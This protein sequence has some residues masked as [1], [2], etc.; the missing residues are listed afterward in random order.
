MAVKENRHP[1]RPADY[2]KSAAY[3]PN[4]LSYD[5][6]NNK[7]HIKDSD[8]N[9]TIINKTENTKIQDSAG[10]VLGTVNPENSGSVT[11][12]DA[13]STKKGLT[14]YSATAPKANSSANAGSANTAARSDH[15]HPLQTNVSG[16]AGTADKLKTKRNISIKGAATAAAVAFDGSENVDLN[17]TSIDVS[18]A[19]G[20]LPISSVPKSA[21]ERVV[22]VTDDD[23]KLKLTIDDI[24]NGDCV[25]VNSTNKMYFVVDENKLGTNEAFTE[26]IVG[27]SAECS[28]SETSDVATKAIQDGEGN[29]IV[30]QYAKKTDLASHIG[31]KNNPHGITAKQIGAL[32]SKP[33]EIHITSGGADFHTELN[34]KVKVL[35]DSL[36]D[37]ES[38]YLSIK[39]DDVSEFPYGHI[40]FTDPFSIDG[41]FNKFSAGVGSSFYGVASAFDVILSTMLADSA[42][43]MWNLRF[44]DVRAIDEIPDLR[45]HMED[46]N[47][48][49]GV[50]AEQVGALPVIK[51]S[52]AATHEDFMRVFDNELSKMK[53]GESK[54]VSLS[55]LTGF[56]T[57][58]KADTCF[59]ILYKGPLSYFY[60][61]INGV[62]ATPSTYR[63]TT[64][65]ELDNINR[66]LLYNNNPHKVTAE[67]VGALAEAEFVDTV[68]DPTSSK[69]NKK[70]DEILSKMPLNSMKML[71]IRDHPAIYDGGYYGAILFKKADTYAA[72]DAFSYSGRRF[73]KIKYDGSWKDWKQED[74]Q[75][76]IVA[77]GISGSWGY[78]KWSNGWAECWNT[79]EINIA[80][81]PTVPIM[82]GNFTTA[83]IRLPFNIVGSNFSGIINIRTGDGIGFGQ[84]RLMSSD[85]A[86]IYCV[87][88]QN[89][90]LITYQTHIICKWK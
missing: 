90:S 34:S 4:E 32:S 82:G 74:S 89:V 19:T 66:H 7:L 41:F 53:D 71:V 64:A 3:Y 36:K 46:K 86:K 39:I 5:K 44:Y 55:S 77:E 75:S 27:T 88:N 8:G 49:H 62:W 23:A 14:Q 43:K 18:K 6:T 33:V 25:K 11:I 54:T 63:I 79:S 2:D 1:I 47:N 78:R 16:N 24:Q 28:H 81:V 38:V 70:I 84:I 56:F 12:P 57:R 9:D 72:I 30:N 37:N 35:Y 21:M 59:A 17:I 22:P 52:S 67:Q 85:Q 29:V 20:V 13:S 15:V 69:F 48:P 45:D 80:G 50:T 58:I 26:F 68:E 83:M 61:K 40:N 76:T 60:S 65:N 42:N 10:T 73:S 31:N 87:S 51:D